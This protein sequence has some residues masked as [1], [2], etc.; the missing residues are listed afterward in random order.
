MLEVAQSVTLHE[1]GC[2]LLVI[3]DPLTYII[4]DGDRL[5]VLEVAKA[6][7]ETACERRILFYFPVAIENQAERAIS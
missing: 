4:G 1:L 6:A 3:S 2:L 7:S 5:E